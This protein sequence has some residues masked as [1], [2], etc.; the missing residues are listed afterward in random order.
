MK[1]VVGIRFRGAGKIYR[2]NA[3]GF[4]LNIME[5]VLV[6]TERGLVMGT[7]VV[8]PR[9]VEELPDDIPLKPILRIA[10]EDDIK[11]EEEN[12]E[13]ECEAKIFCKSCIEKHMLDM[14]LVDVEHL[15]DGSKVIFYF[16]ADERV[17]F[18]AL[19]RD[20]ASKF[21][22]RIE[23]RQIG[24]RNKAKLVGGIGSC[25]RE[26]CCNTFLTNFEPVS[27]KMAKDQNVSLN[28]SKISGVCGRLMCCLKYEYDTY[29]DLKED[30]PKIGKRVVTNEGKGKV[31]RQNVLANSV[32]VEMEDGEEREVPIDCLKNG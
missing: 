12:K 5:R 28:P 23:M 31:I 27:V 1:R 7:V 10:S 22:T 14:Y 6:E 20:L 11:K 13:R 25:G 30:M 8:P 9:N 15:F 29:L 24:V 2:F 3:E 18:R 4:D 19:V 32:T 17:D 21:R 26:L 16:T